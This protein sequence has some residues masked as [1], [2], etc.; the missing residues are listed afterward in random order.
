MN[1]GA[2]V[3]KVWENSPF[4]GSDTS[5]TQPSSQLSQTTSWLN[6]LRARIHLQL[7]HA[8]DTKPRAATNSAVRARSQRPRVLHPRRILDF[9]VL[10]RA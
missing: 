9:R 7:H 6:R 10:N 5:S 8:S 1:P 3:L 2:G 4:Q